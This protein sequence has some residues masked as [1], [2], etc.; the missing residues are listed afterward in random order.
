MLAVIY[1]LASSGRSAFGVTVKAIT[2][3]SL[4]FSSALSFFST[5]SPLI[6]EQLTGFGVEKHDDLADA[7]AITMLKIISEHDSG[8]GFMFV[9]L[10]G[11][12]PM[13]AEYRRWLR[14]D[15]G[16]TYFPLSK[17]Y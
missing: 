13:D 12:D 7:F 6:I 1:F 5:S 15:N 14:P 8:P 10:G 9:A 17:Q 4:V 16:K 11:D 2:G 3:R